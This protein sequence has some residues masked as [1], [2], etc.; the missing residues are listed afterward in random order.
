MTHASE[1]RFS[2]PIRVYWEDTD[3]GGVVYHAAYL[4]FMERARTEWLRALGVEQQAWRERE[5]WVFVVRDMQLDFLAPARLDDLLHVEVR[6]VQTTRASL[7]FSQRVVR[8]ADGRVL[9]EARIRVA[10]ISAS[11]FRPCGVPPVLRE[12]FQ[13]FLSP[14]CE[15]V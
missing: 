7:V 13:R 6:L 15:E 4:C 10:C 14:D 8:E 5:D 11:T 9:L 3:A 2:L 12:Q 1:T